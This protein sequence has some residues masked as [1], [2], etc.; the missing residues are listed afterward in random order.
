MWVFGFD[1]VEDGEDGIRCVCVCLC[2]CQ[3]AKGGGFTLSHT[4]V[5]R[6]TKLNREYDIAFDFVVP[7]H[8]DC[9]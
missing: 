6:L 1:K 9:N 3:V 2:L 8:L 5:T 7:A 4:L